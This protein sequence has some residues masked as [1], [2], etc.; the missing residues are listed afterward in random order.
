MDE[1]RLESFTALVFLHSRFPGKFF[2]GV[3]RFVSGIFQAIL[4]FALHCDSA[5]E[6]SSKVYHGAANARAGCRISLI[7]WDGE[8]AD[9]HN[10]TPAMVIAAI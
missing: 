7:E 8:R 1:T 4:Q 2:L 10:A 6:G 9:L 3:P 5:H